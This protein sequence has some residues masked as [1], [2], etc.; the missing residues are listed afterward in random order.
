MLS[1]RTSSPPSRR[2]G[3]PTTA[4]TSSAPWTEPRRRP[5]RS[6][7][8]SSRAWRATRWWGRGIGTPASRCSQSPCAG[9]RVRLCS[10]YRSRWRRLS[11]AASRCW[12]RWHSWKA[13]MRRSGWASAA[14]RSSPITSCCTTICLEFGVQQGRS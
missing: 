2:T 5:A 4:T 13:S 6:S 3:G 14:S 10:G 7:A 11:W 8:S 12:R 9:R 1:L